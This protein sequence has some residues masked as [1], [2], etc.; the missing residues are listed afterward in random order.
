MSAHRLPPRI[1]RRGTPL[2]LVVVGLA[3]LETISFQFPAFRA[4]AD[5]AVRPTAAAGPLSQPAAAY[6]LS[7]RIDEVLAKHWAA[8]NV[9]PAPAADDGEFLRR[10]FLDLAG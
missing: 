10:V 9:Q 6:T 2:L 4:D 3:A 8:A 1:M 5:P 7:S